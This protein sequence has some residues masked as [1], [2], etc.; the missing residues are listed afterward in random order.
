VSNVPRTAAARARWPA[1]VCYVAATAWLLAF[2]APWTARPAVA[3]VDEAADVCPATANPCLVAEPVAVDSGAVLD[4]GLRELRIVP[5]GRLE[6]GAGLVEIRCGA[7]T[8][9]TPGAVAVLARGPVAGGGQD[10]GSLMIDA[11]GSC[12]G[13]GAATPCYANAD[14]GEVACEKGGGVALVGSLEA[15]GV[16]AGSL[17]IQAAGDVV[18][19]DVIDLDSADADGDGGQLDV[20][21]TLGSISV[22][23]RVEATSGRFGFGGI[24]TMVAARDVSVAGMI[25]ASGGDFDGGEID[26]VAGG[27]LAVGG[28]LRVDS[29]AGEG[30]GG[31][32]A[33]TA[34]RDLRL[35]S[36]AFLTADGHQSIDNFAGDGGTFLLAAGRDFSLAPGARVV[37]AGARPDAAAGTID[38][39]I[40]ASATLAGTL[41]VV[42][43]GS[44]GIGGSIAIQACEI[45]IP[46]PGALENVGDGGENILT[47]L[48]AIAARAGATI[49]AD[50]RTGTNTFRYRDASDPPLLQASIVPAAT[51]EVTP[52]LPPCAEVPTTTTTT[53]APG[54]CGNGLLDDG[55]QCDDGDPQF[56][57]GDAC[58][59]TCQWVACADPDASGAVNASDALVVL[60]VAVAL[61]SCD[62]C[63]CNVDASAGP[64]GASDALRTLSVAVGLPVTLTCPSCAAQ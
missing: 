39:T 22:D 62:P 16:I 3:E 60:R 33:L 19:S 10:G 42:A 12:I 64:I 5:G 8:A 49:T 30:A 32:V 57:R 44:S 4:F 59:P 7:F 54:P 23:G 34:G 50:A 24:V 41:S 29:T 43:K 51:M 61:E 26:V 18:L 56:S 27:D 6:I 9:L 15:Q 53:L 46:A 40:A 52:Q 48:G 1:A 38:A 37:A 55:E 31:F 11:R 63:V 28:R 20:A 25:D 58:G 2:A 17:S 14:C 36:T 21:S 13:S 47:G 35:T 45:E